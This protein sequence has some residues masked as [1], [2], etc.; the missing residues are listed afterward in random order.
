MLLF[1]YQTLQLL[2]KEGTKYLEMTSVKK[3]TSDLFQKI[4]TTL[5]HV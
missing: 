3:N 4:Q 2:T 1:R 5:P